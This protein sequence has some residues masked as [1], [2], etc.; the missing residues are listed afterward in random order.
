MQQDQS[1]TIAF[2]DYMTRLFSSN[3]RVLGLVRQVGMVSI[4]LLP[5]LKHQLS[6]Q[7]MGLAQPHVTL[8]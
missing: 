8:P 4:D 3:S 1:H 5:P 7:A 6:R 2:S